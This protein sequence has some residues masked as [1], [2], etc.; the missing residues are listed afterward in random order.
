MKEEELEEKLHKITTTMLRSMEGHIA[1]GAEHNWGTREAIEAT[2]RA[3]EADISDQLGRL[4]F[5]LNV[6]S[7]W[8]FVVLCGATSNDQGLPVLFVMI[9]DPLGKDVV[10]QVQK[11]MSNLV[12]VPLEYDFD[13]SLIEDA[14]AAAM[15]HK[16]E[17]ALI[18]MKALEVVEK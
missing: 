9:R 2:R 5:Y 1:L 11:K 16:W 15:V 13:L 6:C 4:K 8:G 7:Y 14:V 12:E 3:V 10:S 17:E 18:E